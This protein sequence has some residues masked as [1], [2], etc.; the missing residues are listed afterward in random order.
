[1]NFEGKVE[2][3]G[4]EPRR[5]SVK[6]VPGT[7]VPPPPDPLYEGPK[8]CPVWKHPVLNTEGVER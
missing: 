8:E 1:M 5:L 2:A 7:P 4:I 3:R 6:P